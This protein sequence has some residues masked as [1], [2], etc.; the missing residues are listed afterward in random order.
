MLLATLAAYAFW[1]VVLVQVTGLGGEYRTDAA[2]SV[3]Y[4]GDWW[5]RVRMLGAMVGAAFLTLVSWTIATGM[6]DDD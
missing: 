5:D 3:L 1:F 6:V 4:H 2:A